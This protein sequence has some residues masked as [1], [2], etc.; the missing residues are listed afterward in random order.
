[1]RQD[2]K[3]NYDI[4][5]GQNLVVGDGTGAVASAVIDMAKYRNVT[6]AV[7]LLNKNTNGTVDMKVQHAVDAAFTIPID[8]DG[9]TGND[10]AITQLD[11]DD[12]IAELNVQ[13]AQ[14][15]FYRVLVTVATAGVDASQVTVAG[16]KV[17][18]DAEA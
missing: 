1:M 5:L 8:E 12:E 7:T 18:V 9:A 3:T 14:N 2:V 4:S 16:P 17:R 10:T 11:T 13:R 6:F 15:R